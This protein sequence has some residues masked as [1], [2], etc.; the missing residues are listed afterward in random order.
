MRI[1]IVTGIVIL[2][3]LTSCVSPSPPRRSYEVLEPG[4]PRVD[5]GSLL[6]AGPDGNLYTILEGQ[7]E[8]R[9]VTTDATSDSLALRYS[10]YTWA[11]DDIV[12]M[13]Q[14]RDEDGSVGTSM[15][16]TAPT[17][18]PKRIFRQAGYAPFFLYPT[19]DG[20]R[21][22]YLGSQAGLGGYIMGSVDL[23]TGDRLLHGRGQPFYSA[24]APD[25]QSL[26]VHVGTPARDSSLALQSVAKATDELP[27]TDRLELEAG[28]FQSPAYAPDGRSIAVVLEGS[29]GETGIHLLD[30]MGNDLGRLFPVRGSVSLGW[31]PN[32]SRM[33]FLDA[34]APIGSNLAGP[35]SIIGRG[36][37]SPRVVS[38][39][40]VAF[41]WSPDS[42]RLVFFEPASYGQD[43]RQVRGFR[44]GLYDSLT[45]E[46]RL[47]A[48]IR[49]APEFVSQFVP[50]FDQYIRAY[51]IWSPDG[52][53]V[54]L[55]TL[56]VTGERLVVVVDT[57]ANPQPRDFRVSA[58][59]ISEGD[60]SSLGITT[61][62]GIPHRVLAYGTLPFFSP[63]E[64][65]GAQPTTE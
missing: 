56:A 62:E 32:G 7:E 46:S 4:L 36:N 9:Q 50:F 28:F 10:G 1:N 15:F 63:H 30:P 59:R 43:S 39:R 53:L 57:E 64:A 54:A 13:T 18:T 45:Q 42:T 38:S 22:G 47:L 8:V 33:A 49:P 44:V 40:A 65:V 2:A 14:E 16:R 11:G 6:F 41:F 17:G 29:D 37:R 3:V 27:E 34:V 60:S 12:Y 35:L 20:T 51:T 26:L 61:P 23:E 31:A 25:G 24:W 55:N 48:T 5:S 52:R 19:L 58:G 21:V